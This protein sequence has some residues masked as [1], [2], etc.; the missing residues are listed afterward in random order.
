MAWANVK[1]D[2]AVLWAAS[3]SHT[4]LETC[5]ATRECLDLISGKA[6]MMLRIVE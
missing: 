2:V 6:D 1:P 3:S 5:F 4:S